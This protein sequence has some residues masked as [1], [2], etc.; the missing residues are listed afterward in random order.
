MN[1]LVRCG[2]GSWAAVTAMSEIE[3]ITLFYASLEYDGATID[4][5]TGSW[6]WPKS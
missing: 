5:E 3:Q 6:E 1:R 4:W 2:Y